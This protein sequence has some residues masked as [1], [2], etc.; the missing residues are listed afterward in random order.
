[1]LNVVRSSNYLF[2]IASV[3]ESISKVGTLPPLSSRLLSASRKTLSI[4]VQSAT[5]SDDIANARAGMGSKLFLQHRRG[6]M[7]S[8][9]GLTFVIMHSCVQ[10]KIAPHNVGHTQS[11]AAEVMLVIPDKPGCAC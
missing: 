7:R 3:C 11:S 6:S 1:M 9:S 5:A 2:T 8:C 4:A 10:R